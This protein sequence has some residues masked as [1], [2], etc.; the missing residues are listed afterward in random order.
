M[1]L[2]DYVEILRARLLLVVA[3]VLVVLAAAVALA[4][5]QKPSY[6]ASTR[7][8]VLPAAP[9]S[10]AEAALQNSSAEASPETDAQ[11][12][13]SDQVAQRV[14]AQLHLA[15]PVT[16]L[17]HDIQVVVLPSTSVLQVTATA[18]SALEAI[19]LANAFSNQYLD[20]S[21]AAAVADLNTTQRNEATELA[22]AQAQLDQLDAKLA[23]TSPTSPNYQQ[24]KSQDSAALAQ[25]V[26]LQGQIQTI[27]DQTA[28][29]SSGFGE[30]IQPA[31]LDAPVNTTHNP[32]VRTVVFGVLIGLPLAL[33]LVLLLD[34]IGD[35]LRGREDAARQVGVD[36]IGMIPSESSA[37]PDREPGPVTRT[38]PFSPAAEAYRTLGYNLAQAAEARGV[39]TILVTSPGE[40]EGKTSVTANVAHALAEAGRMTTAVDGDLR[41]PHLAELMG[42]D[43]EPGLSDLFE[44]HSLDLPVQRLQPRLSLVSAGMS[45]PRPDLTPLKLE[46]RKVFAEA[47]DSGTRR[48]VAG[49]RQLS[50]RGPDEVSLVVI[51]SAPILQASEVT[52]MAGAV[53]GVVIV[54]RSGI[55]RRKAAAGAAEQVRRAGGQVIGVVMTDVRAGAELGVVGSNAP[56]SALHPPASASAG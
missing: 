25:L 19:D 51:D 47:L 12:V 45:V 27:A 26:V 6:S 5:A 14:Q 1:K 9:G 2:V 15:T 11:L 44:G 29:V 37:D 20:V 39:R 3:T 18:G 46:M 32:K 24:I 56:I 22:T 31:G 52:R 38:D 10:P 4:F 16:Q 49:R 33:A 55:T 35:R 50:A 53:D 8:R 30:V 42:G 34:A 28:A 17:V 7:I 13:T 41:S 36:V 21:R 23:S 54:V 40:G 43:P 48:T